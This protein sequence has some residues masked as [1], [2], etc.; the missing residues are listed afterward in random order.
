M[1][2]RSTLQH[3]DI[4]RIDSRE[5]GMM[6]SIAYQ[7]PFD[8]QASLQVQ[9]IDFS[10]KDKLTFGRDPSNDVVLDMPTVSRYH[11]QV[12]RVGKRYFVTDLQSANGT[13]VN[14]ERISKK[15]D[16]N[17]KD[18]LRIGPYRFCLGKTRSSSTTI[19]A[20]CR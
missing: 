1:T 4:L 2:G 7:S 12:E 16:L 6:V 20:V 8:T 17:P 5:P 13:F 10:Q 11:A 9:A 3:G 15:T 18:T 14:N 19:P